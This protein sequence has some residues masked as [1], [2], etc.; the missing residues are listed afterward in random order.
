MKLKIIRIGN[1]QGVYIPKEVITQ[2]GKKVGEMVDIVITGYNEGQGTLP[3]VITELIEEKNNIKEVKFNTEWCP[4]H[5]GVRKGT[6]G[7]Q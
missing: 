5:E 4:K 7:C 3:Q 1:S 2:L 6:C